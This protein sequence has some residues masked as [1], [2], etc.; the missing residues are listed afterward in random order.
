MLKG[1][2]DFFRN[3]FASLFGGAKQPTTPPPTSSP[4]PPREEPNPPVVD[5]EQKD[6]TPW[7]PED[8]VVPGVD[9][10]V[11]DVDLTDPEPGTGDV[12]VTAPQDGSDVSDEGEV[13]IINEQDPVIIVE[14]DPVTID[15]PEIPDVPGSVIVNPPQDEEPTENTKPHTQ[16]YLWCL[17]NGHGSKTAGKRSPV[18]ED[19]RQLLEYRFNRDIVRR[20]EIILK[21]IG[22]AYYIVVTEVN[23]DNFL[24]GRVNRANQKTSTLPKLFVS[25]HSNA[26][27]APFG[28][29]AAPSISGIETWFYH[30]SR[31]GKKMAAVFQKHLVEK[32]GFK[33]RHIKSRPASQFYVLRKTGMT[34]VLTENGFYNN[35]AECIRLLSDEVRDQ[36]AQAHVDAIM[37]VEVWGV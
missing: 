10:E 3:L 17:D 25:V 7:V 16:R 23:T 36:I 31:R 12:D 35:K 8:P 18:L 15:L 30:N 24:E 2:L 21:R 11:P 9:P 33:N 19:G 14:E 27:P 4:T 20:I 13:V 34:A 1:I 6:D 22:V 37:E 28:K 5:Q 26:A 32:T 29:W